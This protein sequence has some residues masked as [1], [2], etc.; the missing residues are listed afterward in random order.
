MKRPNYEI[1]NYCRGC[2]IIYP[3]TVIR[4]T[5]CHYLL[6][7]SPSSAVRKR[8]YQAKKARM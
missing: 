8:K 2:E 5:E 4:C 7:R 1:E 6:A 3:K